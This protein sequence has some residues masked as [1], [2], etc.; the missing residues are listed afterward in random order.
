MVFEL[1]LKEEK[2]PSQRKG[3][4]LA[5]AIRQLVDICSGRNGGGCLAHILFSY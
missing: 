4:T 3:I 1:D 2:G 5:E